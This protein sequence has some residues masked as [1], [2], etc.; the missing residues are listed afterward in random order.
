MLFI[1]SGLQVNICH[2]GTY[3]VNNLLGK[4]INSGGKEAPFKTIKMALRMVQPGDVIVILSNGSKKPY[5]ENIAIKTSGVKGATITIRGE[6][7]DRKPL[8]LGD[9]TG[10]ILR[11]FGKHHLVF[12]DLIIKGSKDQ[13]LGFAKGCSN[14]LIK[15]LEIY[16]T[17]KNGI[18]INDGG[19]NFTISNCI[20]RQVGNTG[21]AMMGDPNSK[22]TQTVVEGCTIS[23]ALTNDGISLH[24]DQLESDIGRSHIIRNNRISN[25]AEQGIDITAGSDILVEDNHTQENHD[26]GIL[27]GHGTSNVTIRRH[28]SVNEFKY[29]IIIGRA[30]NVTLTDSVFRGGYEKT[31]LTITGAED[32]IVENCV[33][34][35]TALSR[36]RQII[37]F[38]KS[39]ALGG[40]IVFR[41]NVFWASKGKSP[42]GV[43]LRFLK[44]W[45][46]DMDVRWEGNTW[47][48]QE[49]DSR[50]FYDPLNGKYD[51]ERFQHKYAPDDSFPTP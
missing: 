18:L 26:S 48:N 1:L 47:Y 14:I 17:S 19:N 21:I 35:S 15:N 22:L 6:S 37:D 38:G 7:S 30:R 45:P 31:V 42:K 32:L 33:F 16:D 41:R 3:Y 4:N 50:V 28:N 11:C 9:A 39:N 25:C 36:T 24:R 43:M 5:L 34:E 8:I 29:G 20:I 49:G 46:G 23:D 12:K 27:L 10:S 2:S 44:I 51:F 13:G 40:K